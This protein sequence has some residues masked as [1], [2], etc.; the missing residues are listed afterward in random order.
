MRFPHDTFSDSSWTSD[1]FHLEHDEG[2]VAHALTSWSWPESLPVTGDTGRV[3]GDRGRLKKANENTFDASGYPRP[4]NC[5]AYQRE[6]QTC[7]ARQTDYDGEG[8]FRA[9][10]C[11]V[12]ALPGSERVR[13]WKC[14]RLSDGCKKGNKSEYRRMRRINRTG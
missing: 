12:R 11:T 3:G 14:M 8:R 4:F 1:N 9:R 2:V 7:M 10:G 5:V 13:T 6:H